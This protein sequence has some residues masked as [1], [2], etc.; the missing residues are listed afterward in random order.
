MHS[1]RSLNKL[2]KLQFMQRNHLHQFAP[3][4]PLEHFSPF[5]LPQRS[6]CSDSILESCFCTLPM[7]P[8]EQ[9][10]RQWLAVWPSPAGTGCTW[11]AAEGS[12]LTMLQSS[13]QLCRYCSIGTRPE[14]TACLLVGIITPEFSANYD[15]VHVVWLPFCGSLVRMCLADNAWSHQWYC[16]LSHCV[17][18]L[19][20]FH[21]V[22]FY[23]R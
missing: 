22:S 3:H 19:L 10:Q 17:Q 2:Q 6:L 21:S 23:Y 12:Y 11:A 7:M 1:P 18:A 15:D 14:L 8:C 9:T 16:L 13:Q 20:F 4:Y 5:T